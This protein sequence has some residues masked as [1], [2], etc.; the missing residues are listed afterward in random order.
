MDVGFTNVGLAFTMKLYK[1][2][3]V[4]C[5]AVSLPCFVGHVASMDE[6]N[7]FSG[8]PRFVFW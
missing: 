3:V 5:C 1:L 6:H 2:L 7:Y 4:M 8:D